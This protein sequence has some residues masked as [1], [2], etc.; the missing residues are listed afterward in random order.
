MC[1]FPSLRSLSWSTKEMME[2]AAMDPLISFSFKHSAYSS[3]HIHTP[4]SNLQRSRL[5]SNQNPIHRQ[6]L[7]H[8]LSSPSLLL[9]CLIDSPIILDDPQQTIQQLT[10][11]LNP[12]IQTDRFVQ[13]LI[14]QAFGSW[15]THLYDSFQFYLTGIY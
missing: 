12:Q 13:Q 14:Q 8:P 9:Q 5:P 2:Y 15:T 1:T 11:R 6:T 4:D 10:L 3:I 7:R